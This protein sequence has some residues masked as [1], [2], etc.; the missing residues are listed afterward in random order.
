MSL[1]P[2]ARLPVAA[3]LLLHALPAAGGPVELDLAAALERAHRAAPDAV[4]ARGQLAV[5]EAAVTGANVAFV[6]NPEVDAGA[7]PRLTSARPIDVDVRI[8]Q[9]LEPWRRGPRRAV[10]R[11]GVAQA[12]ADVDGALRRLDLDVATAFFAALHADRA[13]ELARRAE[14][15][16]QKAV[17]TAERRRKAGDITDLDLDLARTALGRARSATHAN[18]SERASAIGAL[19][20]LIGA[21]PDEV[22][23]VR[24]DLKP[25]ALPDLATLRAAIANRPDVRALDAERT[26]ATA[27]HDLAVANG[28][29]ELALWAGYRREDA[30]S[31]VAGGLR[32]TLPAWNRAQGDKA[33]AAAKER[34]A[35]ATREAVVRVA[36]RQ[37][38][39]A[40]AAYDGAKTAVD[41]F[42]RDVLPGLNDSEQLLEK[43]LAAGQI[44]VSDFLVA[45]Q[46]ILSGR[47]EYLDRLLALATASAAVR[48]VAGGAL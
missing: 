16:A 29:I 31:I 41:V 20:A 46:E 2:V 33:A 11:A 17:E 37:L 10:A 28:R 23:A 48:F 27:E 36:A 15:L 35:I 8:E 3:L 14:E 22:L 34:R 39:D 21:A 12:K 32:F 25:L 9:N 42:E 43:T 13:A 19:A 44:T 6:D 40:L 18:A 47:R 30:D 26:A 45:R 1:V 7:G 38:A 5:A 24:G 4:A